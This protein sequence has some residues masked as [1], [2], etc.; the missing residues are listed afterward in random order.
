MLLT[1]NA[2][3]TASLVRYKT[4]ITHFNDESTLE[5]FIKSLKLDDGECININ[6]VIDIQVGVKFTELCSLDIGSISNITL[7]DLKSD[8]SKGM[9]HIKLKLRDTLKTNTPMVGS[10]EIEVGPPQLRTLMYVYTVESYFP[11]LKFSEHE[12]I[13]RVI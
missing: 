9:L 6:A 7:A 4:K 8:L 1:V 3:N 13:S 2:V 5:N 11:K 12:D 10:E